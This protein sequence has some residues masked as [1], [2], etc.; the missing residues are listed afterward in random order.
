MNNETRRYPGVRQFETRE[1]RLFFGR[2]RDIRD[3]YELICLEKVLVL[4]GKSGYGKSSLLNAGLIPKIQ[5]EK[6]T[7][8]DESGE[9]QQASYFPIVIRMGSFMAKSNTALKNPIDKTLYE[10]ETRL[11]ASPQTAFLDE[12]FKKYH[13]SRSLWYHFK[14][15]QGPHPVNIILIFDQFEEFFS[16][17][18]AQQLA[19][20][21]ELADLL[22]TRVP[23]F[24]RDE[25]KN[26]T[27]EQKNELIRPMDVKAVFAIRSDRIAYL[28]TMK[29]ELPSILH[30]RYELKALGREQAREA[31]IQP[32]G[33]PQNDF[34]SKTFTY[35]PQAQEI[36]LNELSQTDQSA[37]EGIESFQLQILCQYIEG[38]VIEGCIED[39]DGD[40]APDVF[41]EDL[42]DI[43]NIY[44]QYYIQLIDKIQPDCKR[45]AQILIEEK[46]LYEDPVSKENRRLS[47]DGRILMQQPNVDLALLNQLVD[48]FLLRREP[49]SMGDYNYEISHDTLVL[50]ILKAKKER[51]EEEALLA[52]EAL[53]KE[54]EQRRKKEIEELIAQQEKERADREKAE[55]DARRYRRDRN[56]QRILSAAIFI[57]MILASWSFIQ[58]RATKN[59]LKDN[60]KELEKKN[61]ELL[62]SQEREAKKAKQQ[63]EERYEFLMKRAEKAENNKEY[64]LAAESYRQVLIAT[65]TGRKEMVLL[66]RKITWADSLYQRKQ[67]FD[68]L[69][70]SG[71]L[72]G[73]GKDWLS[74]IKLFDKAYK[75][76]IDPETAKLKKG[77]AQGSL[78]AAFV[79]DLERAAVLYEKGEDCKW[80][81]VF[82]KKDIRPVIAYIADK[83]SP[84]DKRT[85]EQLEKHCLNQ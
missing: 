47:I 12:A 13:W 43:A 82:I 25:F 61:Q 23:Q 18:T 29:V 72:A 74:A 76:G 69:I 27:P 63:D 81:E 56:N 37:R 80:V 68:K 34:I 8:V 32:A 44:E 3:L 36:I 50:P 66:N 16:Y 41:P 60:N 58:V 83:I 17:P 84:K 2:D 31:I 15:R 64:N 62:A 73:S 5:Q 78:Y 33:L 85:L 59:K 7:V 19:F 26:L 42:P 1:A 24:L 10:L 39:R 52:Q 38:Q 46:V 65:D 35:T 70:K 21:E 54:E 53:Q 75:M 45:A 49:N 57:L 14:R 11:E 48:S 30:K 22:Y 4:F 40:G 20:R 55:R 67:E 28:D 9:E 71:D 77:E 51:L 6:I 79:K